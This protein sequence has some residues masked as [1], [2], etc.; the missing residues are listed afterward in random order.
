MTISLAAAMATISPFELA[1]SGALLTLAALLSI[2]L[3]LQ[4]E[5]PIVVSVARA[6]VQL[7]A[8]GLAL[9]FAIES[10]SL[11]WIAAL[12]L[13][14]V[15][16]T[17]HALAASTSW[18]LPGF[19]LET[20]GLALILAFGAVA[21]LHAMVVLP[22]RDAAS[23]MRDH[24]IVL[25][26]F[27]GHCCSA[28]A[29]VIDRLFTAAVQEKPRIEARLALGQS[30]LASLLPTLREA[31]GTAARPM[32][33]GMAAAGA[34]GIPDLMAGHVLA[35]R[36]PLQAAMLQLKLLLVIGGSTML[37]VVV[38]A[39]AGVYLLTDARHRLRTDRLTRRHA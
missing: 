27:L 14:M 17:A 38:A 22:G 35:G 16:L 31:I 25:G 7:A 36:D 34:V 15:L 20:L 28:M 30:R 23:A 29:V 2:A 9:K 6:V 37:A 32:L 4:L 18:R 11:V 26:L 19:R 10:K 8:L 24:L 12:A 13:A 21:L 3:R 39:L 33:A 5:L 1:A